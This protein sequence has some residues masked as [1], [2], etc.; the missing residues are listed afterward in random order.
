MNKLISDWGDPHLHDSARNA[1]IGNW[2]ASYNMSY[3]VEC[4]HYSGCK[5]YS[6]DNNINV[7][8][9]WKWCCSYIS[10]LFYKLEL[11]NLNQCN[12]DYK[13]ALY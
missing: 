13:G 11:G 6:D 2:Y 9:T 5:N 12:E 10:V 8:I 3:I 4:C 1:S 7:K